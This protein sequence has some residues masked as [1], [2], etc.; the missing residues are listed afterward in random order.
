[1][2]EAIIFGS[3]TKYGKLSAVFTPEFN[4][5]LKTNTGERVTITITVCSTKG[6]ILQ[7]TYYKKVV[8]PCLQRGFK[9][10]GDDM[11]PAETDERVLDM[12]P[13]TTNRDPEIPLS[14][15]QWSELI[16]WSIR[17]CAEHFNIIVPE[18][19]QGT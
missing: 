19:Y 7:E 11:T 8:L 13:G 14:K 18:P 6:T 4:D 15:K 10:T 9:S 17:I 12:C 3:I 5:L 2:T 1:M 16:E